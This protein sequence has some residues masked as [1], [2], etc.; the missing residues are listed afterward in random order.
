[1]VKIKADEENLQNK[2]ENVIIFHAQ[3]DCL[4]GKIA[5]K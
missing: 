3:S 5:E 4:I 1:M 2:I